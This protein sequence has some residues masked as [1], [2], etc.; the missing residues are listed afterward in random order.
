MKRENEEMEYNGD[1]AY[2]I[3]KDEKQIYLSESFDSQMDA[4]R[5]GREDAM[6]RNRNGDC[7]EYD[8]VLIC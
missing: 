6:E 8:I 1:F 4:L 7:V 5:R 3:L 2:I